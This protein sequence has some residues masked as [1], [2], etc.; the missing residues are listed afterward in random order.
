MAKY[1]T[2]LEDLVG[3]IVLYGTGIENRTIYNDPSSCF[4]MGMKYLLGI[5]TPV[6]FKKASQYFENQSLKDEPE[7]IRLLG[8]ME[9]MNINYSKAFSLYA[10]A[11]ENNIQS[12]DSYFKIVLKER[13]KLKSFFNELDLT[14]QLALNSIITDNL[15]SCMGE[16]KVKNDAIMRIAFIC[17]DQA[18]CRE[19]AKMFYDFK[20]YN[21]ASQWI[22]R[23]HIDKNDSLASQINDKLAVTKKTVKITD[24]VQVV[25]VKGNSLLSN[26]NNYSFDS[27]N[28]AKESWE[29]TGKSNYTKW[30]DSVKKKINSIIK[31]IDKKQKKEK[32]K[33]EEKKNQMALIVLG[34]IGLIIVGVVLYF[35]WEQIITIAIIVGIIAIF[36]Y[37]KS[38]N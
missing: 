6:D 28:K 15:D 38:R 23:G 37:S 8:F 18:T 32:Q 26:M 10:K 9:E 31:E 33:E 13:E 5:D 7:V 20:D 25:S 29:N 27:L 36:G 22:L 34:V 4:I 12:K 21:L 19:A 35:F 3:Q 14:P 30:Y 2:N 1:I 17:N 11:A 16:G 24:T